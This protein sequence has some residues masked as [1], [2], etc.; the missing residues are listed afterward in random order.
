MHEAIYHHFVT[1]TQMFCF[2]FCSFPAQLKT[3]LSEVISSVCL[4]IEESQMEFDSLA[5]QLNPI[6]LEYKVK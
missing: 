6:K 3:T 1:T 4:K 2:L 5:A